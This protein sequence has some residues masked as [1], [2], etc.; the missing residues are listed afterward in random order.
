RD[1]GNVVVDPLVASDADLGQIE[2]MGGIALVII[3]TA[4]HERKARDFAARFGARIAAS[5]GDAPLLSAPV[6]VELRA[7]D[8][9]FAGASVIAFAGLKSPGEIALA[10]PAHRAAIVGDALWGDPAGTVR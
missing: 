2:A 5:A 1:G 9:P 7:G 10:L 8:V 4:D 6:D 3:T